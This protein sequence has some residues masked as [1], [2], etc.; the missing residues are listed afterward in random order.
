MA[1]I[2]G[3][4]AAEMLTGTDGNDFLNGLAGADTLDGGGGIDIAVY[5][6]DG[7]GI[8]ADLG[9]GFVTDG[10]GMIDTLISIEGVTGTAYADDLTGSDGDDHFVATAGGD[11]IKG[12]AGMDWVHYDLAEGRVMVNLMM[13]TGSTMGMMGA[14]KLL[15]IENVSGGDYDDFITGSMMANVLMGGGGA[16]TLLGMMGDDMLDGGDGNDILDAGMGLDTMIGGAGADRFDFS[17]N[18]CDDGA[19]TILDFEVGI[20]TIYVYDTPTTFSDYRFLDDADG[21]MIYL[22]GEPQ[23]YLLGVSAAQF[24]ITDAVFV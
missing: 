19:N 16:D 11:T 24:S 6:F 13:G 18:H 3:S 8:T 9:A 5:L 2:N 4:A 1:Y 21:T 12:G 17:V 22:N 7:A 23:L 10:S 14:D 20:D 15:Q